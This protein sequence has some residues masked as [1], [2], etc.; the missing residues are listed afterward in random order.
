MQRNSVKEFHVWILDPKTKLGGLNDDEHSNSKPEFYFPCYGNYYRSYSN[1]RNPPHYIRSWEDTLKRTSHTM[2]CFISTLEQ[3]I[4]A[5]RSTN[6]ETAI[7]TVRALIRVH[8]TPNNRCSLP[9]PKFHKLS[10]RLNSSFKRTVPSANSSN[11]PHLANMSERNRTSFWRIPSGCFL[12]YLINNHSPT[13][14][15][16]IDIIRNTFSEFP[17]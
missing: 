15:S 11:N 8:G 7:D 16:L 3:Q 5:I 9:T 14:Y 2:G 6:E 10:N 13:K 17:Q 4:R 1:S 12:A